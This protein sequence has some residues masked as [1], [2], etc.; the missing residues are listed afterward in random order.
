MKR[1]RV[2]VDCSVI[3]G[4]LDSEFADESLALFEAARQGDLTLLVSDLLIDEL[5]QA[6]A[7]VTIQFESLPVECIERVF[8]SAETSFL[9]DRYLSA[10]V[11][12]PSAAGDAHHVAVATIC[13]ADLIVSW[14]FKHIVHVNKI[15]LF[16]V[17]NLQE[18]YQPI[19][20]R[21]PRE[22]V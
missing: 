11:V 3:G 1:L 6:P 7:G 22:V 18:G 17:V 2:Y 15:R 21:S 20:I 19:D 5:E 9:R 4:C 12:G 14:N 10:G 8:S 16:N 13:R